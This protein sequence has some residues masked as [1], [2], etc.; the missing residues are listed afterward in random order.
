MIDYMK[1][2]KK[3]DGVT[4][5]TVNREAS[6]VRGMLNRAVEW[7]L[8]DFNPLLGIRLFKESEKREVDLSPED[9]ERLIEALPDPIANIAEFAIYTGFRREN[10]LSLK[11]EQ[12]RL[13][14]SGESGIVTLIVKGG[15]KEVFPLG[16]QAVEV[17]Q[18]AISGRCKGYVFINADT[19]TRYE[20]IHRTFDRAVLNLG[21]KVGETKLRFHDLRHVF[22]TWLHQ[23]GAS[24]DQ[25]RPLLGHRN[26]VTTDRYV[27]IDREAAGKVLSLMP[28][29]K[30]E[31]ALADKPK[32]GLK[33]GTGTL[34]AQ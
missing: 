21:L 20:D 23:A 17:L 29:I 32:E 10:I 34:L 24:L 18:R 9:A 27:T 31:K 11:I 6:F 22:A 2:R 4:N 26:R 13:D 12:V 7:E 1:A 25:L 16:A 3:Q 19:G 8:L 30:Q 15:R 5:A 28:R 14:A 33:S